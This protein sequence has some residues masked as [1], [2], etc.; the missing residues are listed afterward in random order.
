MFKMMFPLQYSTKRFLKSVRNDSSIFSPRVCRVQ[1]IV[2]NFHHFLLSVYPP[3]TPVLRNRFTKHRL[4]AKY[5]I[6][7]NFSMQFTPSFIVGRIVSL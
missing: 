5:F 3:A 2:T 4:H 7:T 6:I 1:I